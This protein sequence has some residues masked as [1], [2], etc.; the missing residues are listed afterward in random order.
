MRKEVWVMFGKKMSGGGDKKKNLTILLL[1]LVIVV[2]L[3]LGFYII[4]YAL[5]RHQAPQQANTSPST[6]QVQTDTEQK[7]AFPESKYFAPNNLLYV[8]YA[9]ASTT[10]Y[11]RPVSGGIVLKDVKPNEVVGVVLK[12]PNGDVVV[13]K[14]ITPPPSGKNEAT[15][16]WIDGEYWIRVRD[17]TDG[18]IWSSQDHKHIQ[19]LHEIPLLF[20]IHY[21]NASRKFDWY[22]CYYPLSKFPLFPIPSLQ[23]ATPSENSVLPCKRLNAFEMRLIDN[24][25]Y[26]KVDDWQNVIYPKALLIVSSLSRSEQIEW[27]PPVKPER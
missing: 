7:Y 15:T 6:G 17:L 23:T 25:H 12:T 24:Y 4:Y 13:Q 22:V 20:V 21:N 2:G 11:Y 16:R 26:A 1:I 9:V 19:I 18:W 27:L 10:H 5:H 3:G 14:K 8:K